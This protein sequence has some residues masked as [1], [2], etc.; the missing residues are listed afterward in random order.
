VTASQAGRTNTAVER[1]LV[2]IVTITS[3]E[4]HPN[5]RTLTIEASSSDQVAPPTLTA[6]A[7]GI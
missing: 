4:F 2:D 3:A 5:V 1:D 7:L 6:V